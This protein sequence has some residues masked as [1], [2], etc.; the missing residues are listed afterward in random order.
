MELC[1]RGNLEDFLNAIIAENLRV[2]ERTIWSWASHVISAL[3]HIHGANVIHLDVK[4]QN[5]FLDRNGC[6]KLGDLGLARDITSSSNTDVV[7]GDSRYMAPELLN[8]SNVTTAVDIFS[9]G[10]MLFQIS[11][12]YTNLPNTGKIWRELRQDIIPDIR[13]AYSK[14]LSELICA[15][16]A[17]NPSRRP[18][19]KRLLEVDT[20]AEA[21]LV[22]VHFFLFF[23]LSSILNTHTYIGTRQLRSDDT[24]QIMLLITT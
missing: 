13:N 5:V 12:K 19:A 6:L 22:S 14:R 3:H 16:M 23:C 15:M 18:S 17:S 2:P 10:I 20:I 7:E 9:L 1:E 21:L 4:P 11:S 24:D 8:A